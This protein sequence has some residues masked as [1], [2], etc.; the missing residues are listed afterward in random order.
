MNEKSETGFEEKV[1]HK[2][3]AKFQPKLRTLYAVLTTPLTTELTTA[4]IL[5]VAT[6][7]VDPT[8][9]T[10]ILNNV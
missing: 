7:A 1:D 10:G 8:H 6:L 3:L 5:P 4:Q 9:A 2:I